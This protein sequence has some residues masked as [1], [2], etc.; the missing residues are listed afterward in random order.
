[1]ISGGDS[2]MRLLVGYADYTDRLSYFDDWRDAFVSAP[3]FDAVSLNLAASDAKGKLP[4]LLREVDA[5]VLLHSTNGDTTIYLEPHLE[6]L[7]DRKVP[8]LTFV[9]NEVNLP[10]SP[11][12]DKRKAFALLRPEYVATQL[13]PEAGK[14]LFEDVTTR[15]VVSIPHA[16]NP[17]VYQPTIAPKD[18]AL[19]IG[20]RATR[21]LP[22]LGDDDRNRLL[23]WFADHGP[24][25]GFHVEV[26]DE[27]LDRSGWAN[28]LNQ[29][30]GTVATEAGSWYLERDDKT[31]DLIRE[32]VL[33]KPSK[34]Y[35]LRN[36][37]ALRRFG[38]RLPWWMRSLARHAMT[39]GPLRHEALVN[40]QAD[41][42]EIFAKFFA[43][44]PRPAH[45][46]K[47]IS[48]RHFDAAG[49]K[50]CQIMFRGRFNDILR[51]DE[52]YLALEP[53]F[54]NIDEVLTLFRDPLERQRR[55]DA[56]FALVTEQHTY[57]H[58]MRQ[59]HDLL[60]AASG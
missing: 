10:G 9:G 16:L 46:A 15:G 27:R 44:R 29:C 1:M 20:A 58:R 51:A 6:V 57:A 33:S 60:V 13:L 43:D 26:S 54:S 49:T 39:R 2:R 31:V 36:D 48:S 11:S 23:Q 24:G 5:V 38:H 30:R 41:H 45:Y 53:D 40:E 50:T 21:Y 37:S 17:S 18:R 42:D 34:G 35:V 22:H 4:R 3:Q 55:A 14:Y 19:D 8:L 56:A 25:R 28:Y 59:I 7:A 32:Y 12:V 47:C 52:H